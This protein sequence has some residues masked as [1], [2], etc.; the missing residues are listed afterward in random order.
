MFNRCCQSAEY[1]TDLAANCISECGQASRFSG[2]DRN[3]VKEKLMSENAIDS[4]NI[5]KPALL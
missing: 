1:H 4:E 3:A 2:D 5:S